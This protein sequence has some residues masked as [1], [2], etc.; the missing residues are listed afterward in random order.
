MEKFNI[1]EY[2]DSGVI[3]MYVMDQLNDAERAE[4]ERLAA[5]YPEI[6]KE[7][8]EVE[9]ALGSYNDLQGL[10]PPDH[11]LGNILE[12]TA[13]LTAPVVEKLPVELPTRRSATPLWPMAAA[14]A[15]LALAA[16]M[17]L[18]KQS[19]QQQARVLQD[20]VWALR[21]KEQTC[22]K[23]V[24]A[25]TQQ[26]T[27][28]LQSDLQKAVIKGGDKPIA[29]VYWDK[30]GQNAHLHL[31]NLENP[32]KNKQYQLWAFVDGKPVSVGVV[33]WDALNKGLLSFDFKK[34]PQAFA[35][36]LENY[37]GSPVPTDVKGAS[38]PFQG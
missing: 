11:I 16:W 3:E 7:L 29:A 17:Y 27:I 1:Q 21:S 2:L 18:G 31:V 22:A 8:A 23:D 32:G 15:G 25:L 9:T 14:V 26:V 12:A 28:L 24:A 38:D 34:R 10:T 35:I 6:R 4:V 37:G 5:Q 33:D 30:K 19:A 36:S 20:E 13:K